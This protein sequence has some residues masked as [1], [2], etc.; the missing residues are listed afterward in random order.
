MCG[1]RDSQE[2]LVWINVFGLALPHAGCLED[3]DKWLDYE[4]QNGGRLFPLLSQKGCDAG[5]GLLIYFYHHPRMSF[6]RPTFML[7]Y[8]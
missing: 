7:S 4:R 2:I 5:G 1:W 8:R 6:S 3:S